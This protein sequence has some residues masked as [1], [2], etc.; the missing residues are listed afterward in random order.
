MD[1]FQRIHKIIAMP[2]IY[3]VRASV[4]FVGLAIVIFLAVA[5]SLIIN[6]VAMTYPL[7]WLL[8]PKF[9]VL[10]SSMPHITSLFRFLGFGSA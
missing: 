1:L 6:A 8:A 2:F 4:R 7:L 3:A 10:N 9:Q 5:I